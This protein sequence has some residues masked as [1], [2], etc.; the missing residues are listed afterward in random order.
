MVLRLGSINLIK[1]IHTFS[2][3]M[4]IAFDVDL[5]NIFFLTKMHLNFNY[6]FLSVN[7]SLNGFVLQVVKMA[8]GYV[9]VC[10]LVIACARR[11]V[12]MIAYFI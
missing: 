2:I 3:L 12:F 8:K 1:S 6:L 7:L 10:E 11:E 9:S 4:Q 5:I